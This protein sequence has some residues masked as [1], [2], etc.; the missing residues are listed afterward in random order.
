M[1]PSTPEL[2]RAVEKSIFRVEVAGTALQLDLEKKQR[3]DR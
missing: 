1:D 2:V 3:H